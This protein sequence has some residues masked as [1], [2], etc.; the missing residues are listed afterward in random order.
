MITPTQSRMGRAALG[1]SIEKLARAAGIG[2]NTALRM[3]TGGN[4][5]TETVKAIVVA[6]KAAGVSFPDARTVRYSEDEE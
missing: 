2:K 6:F 3:E 5:T 4:A 1:W